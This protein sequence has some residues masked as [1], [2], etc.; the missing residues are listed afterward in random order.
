MHIIQYN[1]HF[2]K[3]I[4]FQRQ[5]ETNNAITADYNLDDLEDYDYIDRQGRAEEGTLNI[6]DIIRFNK[7][8]NRKL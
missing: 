6:F 3:F 1:I 8:N 2:D 7:N 4:Y 5:S